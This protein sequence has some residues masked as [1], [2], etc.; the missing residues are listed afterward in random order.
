MPAIVSVASWFEK[1]RA[2]A[3]GLAVCGTGVGVY[4]FS[5]LI[6]YF[7]EKYTFQ[8]CLLLES[9]IIL[10]VVIFAALLRPLESSQK[11]RQRARDLVSPVEMEPLTKAQSIA[12][13]CSTE[14]LTDYAFLQ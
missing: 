7:L 10:N 4:L 9:A 3:M 13:V 14:M 5:T 12:P 1:K 8:D 6:T 11:K 2:T